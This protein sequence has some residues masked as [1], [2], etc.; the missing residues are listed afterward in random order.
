MHRKVDAIISAP[1]ANVDSIP[2]FSV[3]ANGLDL[4]PAWKPAGEFG[5]PYS[6]LGLATPYFPYS[7]LVDGP[8]PQGLSGVVPHA[9][10]NQIAYYSKLLRKVAQEGIKNFVPPKK[11]QTTLFSTWKPCARPVFAENCRSWY[12]RPTSGGYIHGVWLGRG[13]HCAI[14]RGDPRWDDGEYIYISTPGN[15]FA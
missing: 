8:I 15:R 11:W 13:L 3:E 7:L 4:R 14:A 10:K 5:F 1:G 12:N 9:A 6:Y 2:L